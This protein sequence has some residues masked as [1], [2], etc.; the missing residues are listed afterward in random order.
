M[1][2]YMELEIKIVYFLEKDVIRTSNPEWDGHQPDGD[3]WD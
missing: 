2:K 1:Q 3:W